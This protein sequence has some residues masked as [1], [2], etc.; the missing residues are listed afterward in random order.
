MLG[1]MVRL[2]GILAALFT[3]NL[4]I[5]LYNDPDRMAHGPYVGIICTHGMFCRDPLPAEALGWTT[6]SPSASSGGV[7]YDGAAARA[8]E[9]VS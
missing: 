1:F 4:M 7:R 9:L 6:C 8:L 3:L 5:G 2:S